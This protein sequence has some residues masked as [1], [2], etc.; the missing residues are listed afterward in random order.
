[1][2]VYTVYSAAREG[3]RKEAGLLYMVLRFKASGTCN[4]HFCIRQHWKKPGFHD[5]PTAAAGWDAVKRQW[6][7]TGESTSHRGITRAMFLRIIEG[8]R[9]IYHTSV[10][11]AR[12]PLLFGGDARPNH[13]PV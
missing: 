9:T 11:E 8:M 7:H 2:N 13:S 1:M 12:S 10:K 5:I 3:G 4:T 6:L